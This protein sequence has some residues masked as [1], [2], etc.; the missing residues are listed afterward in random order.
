[1][2]TPRERKTL[3]R[4]GAN[5]LLFCAARHRLV[6]RSAESVSAKKENERKEIAA[7]ASSDDE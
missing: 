7:F 5:D 2:S 3:S 6:W 1:M 4:A